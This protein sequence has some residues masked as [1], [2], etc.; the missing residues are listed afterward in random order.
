MPKNPMY[1]IAVD[2]LVGGFQNLGITE[3]HNTQY[4]LYKTINSGLGKLNITL[5]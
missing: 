2:N 1:R 5:I 4:T 3:L